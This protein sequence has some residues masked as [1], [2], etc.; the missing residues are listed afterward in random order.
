MIMQKVI[1][2]KKFHEEIE[3]VSEEYIR[4]ANEVFEFYGYIGK[5]L[6]KK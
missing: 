3:K 2:R 5:G 1:D 4:K 6:S